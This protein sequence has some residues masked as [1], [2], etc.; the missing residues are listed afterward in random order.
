LQY[1]T[2]NIASK[3]SI[4]VRCL[5]KR[6]VVHDYALNAVYVNDE[7]LTVSPEATVKPPVILMSDK[8]AA[9]AH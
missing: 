7:Q 1:V 9:T 8:E 3:N 4:P 5:N 2:A 6:K